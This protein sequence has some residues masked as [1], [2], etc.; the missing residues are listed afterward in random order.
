MTALRTARDV[1]PK[2]TSRTVC[3]GHNRL[4]KSIE[5]A[6]ALYTEF[7]PQATPAMIERLTDDDF[8]RAAR[9]GGVNAPNSEDTRDQVRLLLKV[10]VAIGTTEGPADIEVLKALL[11]GPRRTP[12]TALIALL[13]PVG[14]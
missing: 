9:T 5:M 6:M 1:Y 8:T 7:G 11:T 2:G 10:F 12:D 14:A 13:V 4:V 3:I